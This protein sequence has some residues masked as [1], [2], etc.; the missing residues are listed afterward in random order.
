[1]CCGQRRE[2]YV[3]AVRDWR[4][5]FAPRVR[6][7]VQAVQGKVVR[8]VTTRAG[9]VLVR[10][11]LTMDMAQGPLVTWLVEM[12]LVSGQLWLEMVMVME[13]EC[14]HWATGPQMVMVM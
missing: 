9:V 2:S 1:M 14:L 4:R 8:C 3:Q 12:A 5:Q 11:W 13:M 6:P 10:E 7:A